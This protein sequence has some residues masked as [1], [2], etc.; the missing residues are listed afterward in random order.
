MRAIRIHEY[1]GPEVL[2]CDE[3]DRPSP[4]PG[5]VL[6]HITAASVNP[7]DAAV[8]ENRFPTPRTPPKTI[9]SDGAGVVEQLGAD[10]ARVAIG[11]EVFFT[12]LGVGSEGSYADYAVI[13]EAQ[14]VPRPRDLSFPE[15]AALGL[16]FATAY[17]ALVRRAA[18][19]PGETVMVQGAAGGVGSASVQLAKALG[20]RVIAVVGSPDDAAFARTLGADDAIDF[21]AED[22]AARARELTAGKGVEVVHELQISANLATDVAAIA[23]GGRIVGTGQGPLPEA[24]IPIGPALAGDATLLFMSTSNAGRA[25]TAEMLTEVGRLVDDGRLRP[26]IGATFRLEEAGAAHEALAGRHRGK[27]VLLT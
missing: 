27:I 17:Y 22:V 12:G 24:S 26:V 7:I 5:Q 11:D 23:R 21:R 20:A 8:R 10:V 4:G 19:L 1:G 2:V 16:A 15:A 9:G 3:V 13:A 18:V 25:G 6:V 14:A